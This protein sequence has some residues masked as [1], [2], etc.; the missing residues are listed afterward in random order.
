MSSLNIEFCEVLRKSM[1]KGGWY[2]VIWPKSADIFSTRGRVKVRGEIG[3]EPFV[4]SF[5]PLGD[6]THKL[7]V[8]KKIA[9]SLNVKEG[10]MISVSLAERLG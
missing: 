3:G 9:A 1:A 5:M 7:P 6:G 2:Y 10:D 8:T 4:S